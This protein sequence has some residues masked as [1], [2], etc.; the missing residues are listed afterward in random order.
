MA[1]RSLGSSDFITLLFKNMSLSHR[2]RFLLR[3]PVQYFLPLACSLSELLPQTQNLH[4]DVSDSTRASREHFRAVTYHTCLWK[5]YLTRTVLLIL[6]LHPRPLPDPPTYH[7]NHLF[8]KKKIILEA[9]KIK[10]RSI[11]PVNG[12]AGDSSFKANVPV[13]G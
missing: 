2:E 12:S 9:I 6:H 3:S 13:G 5:E 11:Q 1:T 4:S 10:N 7:S 8:R